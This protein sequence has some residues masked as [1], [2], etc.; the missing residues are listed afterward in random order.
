VTLI[1]QNADVIE[2]LVAT[3]ARPFQNRCVLV[4][5]GGRGIGKRLAIGFARLGARVALVARS[6]AELDL[7]HIEIEQNGGNALRIRGDV[8]DPEQMTVAVDRVRVAYGGIPDIL[9]C[10]AGVAGPLH[11]FLQSSLKSWT[12]ALHINLM[13]VVNACRAVLPGMVER[14]RGKIIVLACDSGSTPKLHFSSYTTAK[15]AVVRF[16]ESIA[17][18]LSE[19]N[20]QINCLDPGSAYTSLTDEIIRASARVEH[21]VVENA[22]ETRRT[23]GTS[24]EEQIKLAEFLASETSNH[25]TGRFIHVDDDWKKLKTTTLKADTFT[26]RRV[27]K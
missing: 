8:A 17:P 5:G 25:I 3:T 11:G 18:E 14:R 24:P 12:E 23:G 20:V 6:K 15:T 19:H 21:K 13:G 4:T 26:L 9:I 16:V 1:F 27:I 22:I 10:A 2:R 7:A